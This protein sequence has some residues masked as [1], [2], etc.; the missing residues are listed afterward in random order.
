MQLTPAQ[1]A[2]ACDTHRF[3]VVDAGRRFGKTILA[4][5]EMFA[6]AV[7]TEDGRVAYI[8]PTFQQ[9]RDIA[10]ADLKRICEPLITSINE[11]RLEITVRNRFG[12]ASLI[13]LRGWEAVE[14]L[15]GQK[16]DLLVIDE[17]AMMRAFWMHW[18]EV[19]RPTLTDR[20]GETL[21]ISTPRGFNHFY[22][23]YNLEATDPDFKSF[24]FTSYDNPHLP[25]EE[26]DKARAELTEDRFAQEYLADFRKT[27]GLVY[28]EFS[29][30]RHLFD[31]LPEVGFIE[32]I[33]GVDFGF[34]HPAAVPSIRKDY[35]GNYWVTDEWFKTGQTDAQIAEYVASRRF[36]KVYP[37]PENAGGIQELRN[38]G[39][40]VREVIKGAGS[41]KN[42]INIVRELLKADRLH[43][44]RQCVHTIEGFETYSYPPKKHGELY[45]DENPLKEDDDAMDGLR[46]PLMMDT[47]SVGTAPRIHYAS[48]RPS[49]QPNI[50]KLMQAGGNM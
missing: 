31:E 3:R 12:G 1:S 49:S 39:V 47:N 22:D 9:A 33:A 14:T 10:W 19:L 11:S 21:F 43:I 27:E 32:T 50:K 40:N 29:R 42:G 20:K 23:L 18:Q 45:D 16:F 5:W 37:D 17:I 13:I 46:Y 34:T 28:K 30:Q 35:D 6:K 15:R 44:H 41:V 48:A 2:I 38:H 24:H 26:I 8:A 7:A 25:P 36:S 4:A